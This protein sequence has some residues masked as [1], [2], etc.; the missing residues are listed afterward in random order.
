MSIASRIQV[1]L[2]A[3]GLS[4][5]RASLDAGLGRSA[6]GDILAGNSESPR[7]ATLEALARVLECSVVYLVTGQSDAPSG[8]GGQAFPGGYMAEEKDR[9]PVAIYAPGMS[10]RDAMAI[11]ALQGVLAS[12]GENMTP[13]VTAARRSYAYA[14]AML[15]ERA[16]AVRS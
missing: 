6:I 9:G 5:S 7:V 2:D 10:L 13:P 12:E 1:R 11:G 14:D 3:L 15:A 4:A 8:D 16:K